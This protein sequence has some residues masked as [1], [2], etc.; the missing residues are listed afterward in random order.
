M[1][2]PLRSFT[3]NVRPV[4]QGHSTVYVG[5]VRAAALLPLYGRML[6][7]EN[8][9]EPPA[10]DSE[11]ELKSFAAA[12]AAPS[13]SDALEGLEIA[14]APYS[15]ADPFQR[16]VDETRV[17]KIARYLLSDGSMIP[18][19]IILAIRD[20][21]EVT[22]ED[23]ARCEGSLRITITWGDSERPLNVIDGQHRLE[24]FRRLIADGH[25]QFGDYALCITLLLDLPYFEQAELFSVINGQQKP[26]N[27]SRIYDL[28]GYYPTHDEKLRHKAFEGELAISR[29]C[30]QIVKVLNQSKVSPWTNRIK[31]RGEGAGVV[32]QAAFVDQLIN[33][34][35]PRKRRSRM[36]YLPILY[37]Y[38]RSQ[39]LLTVGKICINYFWAVQNAWP[40]FWESDTTLTHSL[41]GKTNGVAVMLMV[42]HDL[43]ILEGG[44]SN[45]RRDRIAEL[46]RKVEPRIIENPPAGG[47]RGYQRQIRTEVMTQMLGP[48]FESNLD[49]AK[50][51][52]AGDLLRD[53]ALY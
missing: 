3:F 42:F 20:Q 38:F 52:L 22:I 5:V 21:A 16:L 29:F 19:A 17:R 27:R 35:Q 44:A 37:S 1:P 32:S 23:D 18:N 10:V 47:S 48:N 4:R 6:R 9:A 51:A 25:T 43:A 39:D 8:D 12:A 24:A 33:L 28:L 40:A 26:V 30:H 31:M 53:G 2:S 14:D 36:N 34:V 49:Q 7:R 46:W 45:L 50:E 15:E 41:F 13:I 11:E